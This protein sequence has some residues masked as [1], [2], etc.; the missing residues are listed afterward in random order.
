MQGVMGNSVSSIA[1]SLNFFFAGLVLSTVFG[2]LPAD[3]Q[4]RRAFLVGVQHYSDKK[5]PS[6]D[7]TINDANDL[8][9]DLEEVGFDKKNIKVANDIKTKDGFDKE[10][11]AFLKTVE[12]GDTVVF[13]FSGHGFGIEATKTNYLLLADLK[14]PFSYAKTQIPEKDRKND[15]VVRLRIPAYVEAYQ[16]NEVPKSGI[17][18]NEI[19]NRLAERN[20]KTVIMIL[21]ACRSIMSADPSA[22]TTTNDPKTSLRRGNDSGSRLVTDHVP[23]PGFAIMYSASFGEQALEKLP[24]SDKSRNSV[25][26]GVLRAELQ[27]PG[28]SLTELGAR[29]K[30]VVR[31]VANNAGRQQEPDFVGTSKETDEFYFVG[32]I[33]RERFQMALGK[34]DGAEDD[35]DQIKTLRKRDLYERHRRRFDTCRTG[36]LARRALIQLQ[37]T[38]DDPTDGVATINR[39]VN[40]CDKLAAA[41]NDRARPPEVP[42]VLID[43]IEADEAIDACRKAAT[44]NPRVA[45]FQYNLGRAYQKKATDPGI[46]ELELITAMREAHVNLDQ[47]GKRGYVSALTNLAVLY[48]YAIEIGKL[49]VLAEAGGAIAFQPAATRQDT[50]QKEAIDLFKRA[51]QQGHPLAMYALALHYRE[52]ETVRRDINQAAELLARSAESGFVS[53]MFEHGLDLI[54]GRGVLPSPRRGI[55]WLQRAAEAGSNRAK[56]WLGRT[57]LTGRIAY[58]SGEEDSANTVRPDPTLALLWLGRVGEAKDEP[59]ALARLATLMEDGR[60]LP[61]PQPEIAERYWRLAAHGGYSNAQ[62]EF[63][64]RLR[65]GL[66]LVKQEYGPQEA[67]DLL[68]RAISQGSPQ[69]ALALAQII[70]TGELG[71]N[72]DA[73]EAMRLAYKTI[74]LAVQT[75]PTTEEGNPFHEIAAAHLLVEMAKSGEAVDAAG[76]P[77]LTESEVARLERFYGSVDPVTKK[78]KVRRLAVP[79]FCG[80]SGADGYVWWLSRSIWVW[81]WG[82][83]ESPTEAQFRNLE[84]TTSCTN[85]QVLRKTLIDVFEQSKKSKLP[86]A[87]LIEQKVKTADATPAPGESGSG[88]RRRR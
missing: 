54:Y 47:A 10:F 58:R 60:G 64:D 72:P 83:T 13:F 66:I 88:R 84:R 44:D 8:A 42:G 77:L 15:D 25:F 87:D 46:S 17:S 32:T 23:P 74:D 53:A 9:K 43:K 18:A 35:W 34:C 31:V 57:Y 16:Q 39:P 76:R 69:A 70:R 33:G 12:P 62:A 82:R 51:A 59:A 28:Q 22:G 40:E 4:T 36:D 79:L 29:V 52:G 61:N 81:D 80:T 73:I 6:L 49:D 3:A 85:N 14:S 11:S 38:A 75:D 56:Y 2:P 50:V 55:E 26:T 41:E 21:D 27:R 37:L 67:I 48:E 45:R 1:R 68:H 19:E 24:G 86:F 20:P 65:R 5:V 30:L 71:V 7:L 78:V 63:A